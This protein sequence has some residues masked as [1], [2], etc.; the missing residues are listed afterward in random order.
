MKAAQH[1]AGSGEFDLYAGITESAAF[2]RAELSARLDETWSVYA[3][4]MIERGLAEP[5]ALLRDWNLVNTRL[6]RGRPR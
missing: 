6:S 3:N 1:A 2:G 5:I 4:G